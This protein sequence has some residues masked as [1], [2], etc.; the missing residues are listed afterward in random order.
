MEKQ[1]KCR[2]SLHKNLK[3]IHVFVLKFRMQCNKN[4]FILFT[5]IPDAVRIIDAKGGV[6]NNDTKMATVDEGT[7]VTLRCVAH[8]GRPI[9]NVSWQKNGKML[10]GMLLFLLVLLVINKKKENGFI[11]MF[12][13]EYFLFH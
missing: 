13:Y 2:E 6:I 7:R 5:V 11:L 4:G 12:I 1:L 9:P 3:I 8:G 10:K